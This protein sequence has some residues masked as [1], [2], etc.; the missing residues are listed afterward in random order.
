MVCPVSQPMSTNASSR[1]LRDPRPL[2]SHYMYKPRYFY[3]KI[4]GI[5]VRYCMTSIPTHPHHSQFA[6]TPGFTDP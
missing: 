4:R 5:Y 6:L 1:L 3:Y 2:D